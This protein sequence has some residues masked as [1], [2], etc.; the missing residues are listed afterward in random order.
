[1]EDFLWVEKYRPRKIVDCILPKDIMTTMKSFA[2]G[3]D[4]KLIIIRH[5]W[6][7]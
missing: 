3:K 1:M 6:H 2:S 5:V 4:T 7:W